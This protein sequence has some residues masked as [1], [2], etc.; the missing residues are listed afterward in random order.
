[1]KGFEFFFTHTSNLL[2]CMFSVCLGELSPDRS[3]GGGL[4]ILLLFFC[5]NRNRPS[6][7]GKSLVTPMR[8]FC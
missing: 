4:V 6:L 8:N 3:R 5:L 7:L 1:M 2:F